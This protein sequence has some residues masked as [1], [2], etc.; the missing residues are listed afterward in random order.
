[1]LG[2]FGKIIAALGAPLVLASACFLTPAP[3]DAAANPKKVTRQAPY[4]GRCMNMAGAL[5]ADREG[6]WGYVIRDKDLRLIANAGFGAIRL[7]VKFSAHALQ[8]APYTISPALFARVD[9]IIKTAN[10]SGLQVILDMHHYDALFEDPDR[11]EARFYGMWAQIAQ[12][13]QDYSDQNLMFELINEPRDKFSGDRMSAAQNKAL[14]IVRKTNPTRTVILSGDRWGN[15][16]G[17]DSLK[18]PPDPHIMV[19]VHYYNPFSFTHQGASWVPKAPPI[20]PEWGRP[21]EIREV[22]AYAEK[23][24]KWQDDNKAPI[25]LGEFGAINYAGDPDRAVWTAAVR[26]ALESV[27]IPWCS[28]D[29]ATTFSVYDQRRQNWRPLMLNALIPSNGPPETGE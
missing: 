4:I 28:F 2:S 9:H 5:E 12:R 7:P 15:F 3:H 11:E 20:G 27:A 23:M 24:A 16:E 14:S 8:K 18:L 13:Y 10:A 1:M 22:V 26:A 17:I 6:D 25:F 19:S 29:F 21:Q